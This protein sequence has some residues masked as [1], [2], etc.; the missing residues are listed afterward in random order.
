MLIALP[1][2]YRSPAR[3]ASA[4]AR[5][6]ARSPSSTRPWPLRA[7]E[8]PHHARPSQAACPVAL[9]MRAAR[10]QFRAANALALVR[11]CASPRR[12]SAIASSTGC[13][14]RPAASSASCAVVNASCDAPGADFDVCAP[15][16]RLRHQRR[17]PRATRDV[18][19]RRGVG[20][21]GI[22]VAGR[23]VAFGA[24]VEEI[25]TF[26][27]REPRGGERRARR[28]DCLRVAAGARGGRDLRDVRRADGGSPGH[29]RLRRAGGA[30]RASRFLRCAHRMSLCRRWIACRGRYVRA[31]PRR[32]CRALVYRPPR[33]WPSPR[34]AI[35]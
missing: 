9:N 14:E 15:I 25:E 19:H 6:A 22:E 35:A 13:R 5:F 16:E 20:A 10:V 26:G 18:E 11:N 29:G 31:S 32:A 2:P 8:T 17:L 21:R 12:S 1:T 27:R 30:R 23:D 4:S 24:Q 3:R 7:A 34:G 28:H 33:R